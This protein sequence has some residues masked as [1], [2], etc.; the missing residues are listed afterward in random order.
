MFLEILL[1][2]FISI[3]L[4]YLLYLYLGW[5]SA[6]S[7]MYALYNNPT[8]K[9]M[10]LSKDR[11]VLETYGILLLPEYLAD[12]YKPLRSNIFYFKARYLER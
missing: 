1:G 5:C 3:L 10:V 6:Y 4:I 12:S 9:L 11:G 8:T 2:A 7:G